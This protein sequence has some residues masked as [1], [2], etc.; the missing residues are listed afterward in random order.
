MPQL[1][2]TTWLNQITSLLIAFWALTYLFL[3]FFLD[4]GTWLMKMRTKIASLRQLLATTLG[5]QAT[6]LETE[7]AA[8]QLLVVT[9]ILAINHELVALVN[10]FFKDAQPV[11]VVSFFNDLSTLAQTEALNLYSGESAT[12]S[13]T[14][15]VED[16][17][18]N[19]G[20]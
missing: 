5:T 3:L 13:L 19:S 1:D 16:E 4:K 2:V 7:T 6:Q 10:N 15:E 8:A 12:F 11:E 18:G 20:E 9:Q 14:V 17:A